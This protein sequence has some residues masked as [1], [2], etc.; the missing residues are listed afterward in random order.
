ARCVSLSPLSKGA[1]LITGSYDIPA[2]SLRALAIF[3][4][5]TPTQAYRSSGRPEV[6]FA[7]ERLIDVA[8][9]QLGVD[10][11]ALRRRNL[12]RPNRM[13]YRNA[14]GMVYDS[15][16][17]EENMNTAM[18]IADWKGFPTRRRD[19]RRRGR[20]AGIGIANYVESSIGAPKEQAR[21]KVQP[22]GRIDV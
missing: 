9:A 1:G 10:R 19:A 6:T 3:T 22:S 2:A 16:R 4:N 18:E 20:L 12:V 11:V 21:I 15:G 14:V 8:A 13:P 7:I 17:Y 5:T